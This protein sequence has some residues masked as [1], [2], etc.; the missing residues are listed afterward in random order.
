MSMQNTYRCPHGWWIGLSIPDGVWTCVIHVNLLQVHCS[1]K[2]NPSYQFRRIFFWKKGFILKE[3][4]VHPNFTEKTLTNLKTTRNSSKL[5]T[6]ALAHWKMLNTSLTPTPIFT[7]DTAHCWSRKN[8]RPEAYSGA[9]LM[10]NVHRA[11]SR[12]GSDWNTNPPSPV[13][14]LTTQMPASHHRLHNRWRCH[15]KAPSFR[16]SRVKET[17]YLYGTTCRSRGRGN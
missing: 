4:T 16:K 17:L 7:R 1:H 6:D 2:W 11:P 8:H 12:E 15:Y 10:M 14:E 9:P 3:S 5:I 13:K